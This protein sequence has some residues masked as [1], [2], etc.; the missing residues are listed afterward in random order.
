[1]PELASEKI[2][3]LRRNRVWY[4]RYMDI[5]TKLKDGNCQN[6]VEV[7]QAIDNM[8]NSS[9]GYGYSHLATS[10]YESLQQV[11]VDMGWTWK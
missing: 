7:L 1:M 5:A 3:R 8:I 11:V 9:H 6:P 10:A 2:I 4:Q